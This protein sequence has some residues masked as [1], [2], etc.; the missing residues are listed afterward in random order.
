YYVSQSNGNCESELQEIEVVVLEKPT[1]GSI[2][3]G[4]EICVNSTPSQIGNDTSGTG[5]GTISYRWEYSED[6]GVTWEIVSGQS[7]ENYQPE[8]IQTSTQFR[9]ITIANT[10]GTLCESE[11]SNVVTFT[12]KNCM[13]IT[14]PMLPSKAKR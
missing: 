12:T 5:N 1:S 3:G 10:S 6:N 7:Q 14:N 9:R 13:V 4:E 8:A 11:P 2:T